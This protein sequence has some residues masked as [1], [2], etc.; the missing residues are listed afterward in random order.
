[1]KT[2][3]SPVRLG[4]DEIHRDP[5]YRYGL[6]GQWRDKFRVIF[7][8]LDASEQLIPLLTRPTSTC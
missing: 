5:T 4:E 6:S 8:L 1:M 3:G 2:Y 7:S